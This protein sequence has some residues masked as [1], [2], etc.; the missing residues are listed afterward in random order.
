MIK[1]NEMVAASF[2]TWLMCNVSTLTKLLGSKE[3]FSI[4]SF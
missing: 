4:Q 2:I 1:A 3:F